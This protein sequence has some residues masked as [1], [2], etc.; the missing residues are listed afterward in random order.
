LSKSILDGSIDSTPPSDNERINQRRTG[1]IQVLTRPA[2]RITES[3]W[4][5]GLAPNPPNIGDDQRAARPSGPP[6]ARNPPG[7]DVEHAAGIP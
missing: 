7:D 1:P 6:R 5:M 3:S 2:E 4:E